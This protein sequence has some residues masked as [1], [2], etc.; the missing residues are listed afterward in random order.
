M[1]QIDKSMNLVVA[2]FHG[3]PISVLPLKHP[4]QKSET[5]EAP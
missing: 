5:A 3:G 4:G 1:E 2:T